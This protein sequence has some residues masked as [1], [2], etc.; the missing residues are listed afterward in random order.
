M[1]TT[2]DQAALAIMDAGRRLDARGWAMG[3]AGNYSVRLG[4]GTFAVTLS[5]RHKGHLQPDDIMRVD[6]E[7]RSMDGRRPSAET[8][9]HVAIYRARPLANAVLH[10]HS[11]PA[12]VLG[13]LRPADQTLSLA[14]YEMLKALP[15]FDTHEDTATIPVLEND[16]DMDRLSRKAEHL[17][18]AD[19]RAPAFLIREHGVY[20]WGGSM[21]EAIGAAEGLEYLLACELE[22]LRCEGRS[23]A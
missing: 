5:G 9:A 4:D 22:I 3:G 21:Q 17:L 16:Q 10:T 19:P 14:G 8:L 11:V 1:F 2:L 13:R 12:V 20:A 23:P 15:G 18:L 7:G 6:G